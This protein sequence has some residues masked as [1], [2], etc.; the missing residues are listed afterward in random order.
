MEKFSKKKL[1]LKAGMPVLALAMSI[2][3]LSN[4]N[5]NEANSQTQIKLRD[6]SAVASN[7]QFAILDAKATEKED[8]IGVGETVN[9]SE[10]GSECTVTYNGGSATI[11]GKKQ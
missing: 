5:G 3:G 6:V 9:C 2:W 4:L 1:M 11:K 8:E 7:S 10:N